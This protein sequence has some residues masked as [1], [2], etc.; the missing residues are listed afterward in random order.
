MVIYLKLDEG[1]D[2]AQ[3]YLNKLEC[4]NLA[5]V[6]RGPTLEGKASNTRDLGTGFLEECSFLH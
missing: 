1:G 3:L 4:D 2:V 5:T 6:V